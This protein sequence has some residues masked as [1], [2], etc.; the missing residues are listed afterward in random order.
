M[1]I[2]R[3]VEHHSAGV[4]RGLQFYILTWVS[5]PSSD[6]GVMLFGGPAPTCWP[7]E[8]IW[9]LTGAEGSARADGLLWV[10]GMGMALCTGLGLGSPDFIFEATR[11]AGIFSWPPVDCTLPSLSHWDGNSATS[12]QDSSLTH[13][14]SSCKGVT[15]LKK[16]MCSLHLIC[17]LV[18]C[19]M[20]NLSVFGSWLLL[21]DLSRGVSW[22]PQHA[23]GGLK[24]TDSTCFLQL[25][26]SC[27][28][29]Q[30]L[31]TVF[32]K[33]KK[34]FQMEIGE[35]PLCKVQE[36]NNKNPT[37]HS[38]D[39]PVSWWQSKCS[40]PFFFQH[41]VSDWQKDPTGGRAVPLPQSPVNY[42]IASGWQE[43][44]PSSVE[45]R[46]RDGEKK[47]KGSGDIATA[48]FN[49]CS[50]CDYTAWN[51]LHSAASLSLPLS[52]G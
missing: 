26:I 45:D 29:D 36:R 39:S 5:S 41:R 27:R 3:T 31:F 1:T 12:Q 37:L 23:V 40:L 48:R 21:L 19:V 28:K 8:E 52:R 14:W 51:T 6:P 22:A 42:T 49:D 25:F 2:S 24:P 16:H 46:P 17:N 50:A 30:I 38:E 32:F 9:V 44:R 15:G 33:K 4:G 34:C 13:I 10:W 43:E 35:N 7:S 18:I 20:C 47:R 11:M